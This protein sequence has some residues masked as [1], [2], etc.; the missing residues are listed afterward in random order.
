M[1][2]NRRTYVQSMNNMWSWHVLPSIRLSL[3]W[4]LKMFILC[5]FGGWIRRIQRTPFW[6]IRVG[7]SADYVKVRRLTERRTAPG[8]PGWMEKAGPLNSKC[9]CK[10]SLFGEQWPM[11]ALADTTPV[12][13]DQLNLYCRFRNQLKHLGGNLLLQIHPLVDTI[14]SVAW[15][16]PS[17]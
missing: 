13:L 15:F 9:R 4:A 14:S 12:F 1:L 2:R 17:T 16:L 5:S 11:E 3:K 8:W 7:E 6:L 10:S